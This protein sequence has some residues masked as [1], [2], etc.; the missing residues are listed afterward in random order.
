MYK[1]VREWHLEGGHRAVVTCERKTMWSW[2]R[3]GERSLSG[4][5]EGCSRRTDGW[6]L[7]GGELP[8]RLGWWGGGEEMLD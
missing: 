5:R 2:R 1:P 6:M 3:Y 7:N 4:W 8:L